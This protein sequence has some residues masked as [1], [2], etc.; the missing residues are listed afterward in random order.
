[1]QVFHTIRNFLLLSVTPFLS[2]QWWKYQLSLGHKF[3]TF[4]IWPKMSSSSWCKNYKFLSS[5]KLINKYR[6]IERNR[7]SCHEEEIKNW[8]QEL[9]WQGGNYCQGK[10]LFQ[11]QW[12][13][14][15]KTARWTYGYGG[16][17]WSA[18][19]R[20]WWNLEGKDAIYPYFL[21]S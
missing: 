18:F 15:I 19:R 17:C 5:S 21:L 1:M 2:I 16:S 14:T 10:D 6:L 4:F 11:F 7:Q 9:T 20:P 13:T 3:F 8:I 12:S